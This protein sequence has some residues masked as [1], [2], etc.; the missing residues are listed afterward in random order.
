M[1]EQLFSDVS[2]NCSYYHNQQSLA[3]T[4]INMA[5]DYVKSPNNTINVEF[6][7]LVTHILW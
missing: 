7:K 1:M 2:K 3:K 4:I 5:Q 6:C